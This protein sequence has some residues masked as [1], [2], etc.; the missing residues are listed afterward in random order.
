MSRILNSREIK[1]MKHLSDSTDQAVVKGKMPLNIGPATLDGLI[2]LGLIEECI[3]ERY[4]GEM[5]YK[6]TPDGWRCMYGKTFE[7]IMTPPD[8][9]PS[10]P[11]HVWKWPHD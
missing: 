8:G 1:V 7:E 5:G 6:I 3:S 10:H 9:K 2:E 4:K 11:L